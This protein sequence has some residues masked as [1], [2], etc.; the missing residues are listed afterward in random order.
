VDP[1]EYTIADAARV[2]GTSDGAI[3][4]RIKR[5]TLQSV[6]RGGRVYVILDGTERVDTPSS[7]GEYD[8]LRSVLEAK[9]ETIAAL[10]D[11]LEAQTRANDENRRIIGALTERLALPAPERSDPGAQDAATVDEGYDTPTTPADRM[12]DS[13]RPWYRRWFGP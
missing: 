12:G 1:G 9:D 5:K 6:K 3:R 13:R 10:R 8:A 4:Q 11:Q 2:L 7:T